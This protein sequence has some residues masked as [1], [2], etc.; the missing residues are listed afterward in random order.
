MTGARSLLRAA[1]VRETA[2]RMLSLAVHGD[3]AEWTVDRSRLAA[4]ADF[5]A[6]VVRER[7]PRLNVP[8]HSRWRH[9]EFGDRNLWDAVAAGEGG[10]N[11]AAGARAGARVLVTSCG[12][13]SEVLAVARAGRMPR[14]RR[15]RP[16]TW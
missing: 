11:A 16:S 1:A 7:Y 4:T 6:G 8:M 10:K 5:V 15:A 12:P 13:G 2:Q 3:L 14:P 9:F